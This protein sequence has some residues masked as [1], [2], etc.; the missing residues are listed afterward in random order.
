MQE[1]YLNP[2]IGIFIGS[3]K[4]EPKGITEEEDTTILKLV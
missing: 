4:P 2:E 3:G 1:L